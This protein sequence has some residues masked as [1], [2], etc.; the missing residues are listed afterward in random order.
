MVKA[1]LIAKGYQ[2][3]KEIDYTETFS[4]VINAILINTIL[5]IA[6]LNR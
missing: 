3:G 4:L 5:A 6:V 2:Q 1:R